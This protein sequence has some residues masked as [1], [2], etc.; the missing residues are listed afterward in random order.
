MKALFVLSGQICKIGNHVNEDIDALEEDGLVDELVVVVEEDLVWDHQYR[1]PN[2]N[3][4]DD[5]VDIAKDYDVDADNDDENYGDQ[6]GKNYNFHDNVD[7]DDVNDN[8]DRP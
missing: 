6:D 4:R 2:I 8:V 7:V 3:N 1:N 5:N